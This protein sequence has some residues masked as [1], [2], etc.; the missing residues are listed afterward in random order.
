MM[1]TPE[2]VA[3]LLLH[4]LI[5]CLLLGSVITFLLVRMFRS[6]WF[7]RIRIHSRD[8]WDNLILWWWKRRYR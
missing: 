1:D 5:L 4:T 6:Y 8:I 7:A 3:S 2:T